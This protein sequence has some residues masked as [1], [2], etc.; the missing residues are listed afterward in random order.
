MTLNSGKDI[1]KTERTGRK[2]P[3]VF[4]YWAEEV[5]CCKHTRWRFNS[6]FC[7]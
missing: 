3:H 2:K 1:I 5:Q 7:F 6:I 4:N